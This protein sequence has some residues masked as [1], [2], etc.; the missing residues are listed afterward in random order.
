MNNDYE[1]LTFLLSTKYLLCIYT[2]DPVI[3]SGLFCWV[4]V[5]NLY[6][7]SCDIFGI[8]PVKPGSA[9]EIH[10]PGSVDGHR[11]GPP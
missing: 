8:A 5:I 4:L 10:G 3:I 11:E 2:K 1:Y 9:P 7:G 6:I